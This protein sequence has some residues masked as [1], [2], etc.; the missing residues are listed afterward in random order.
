MNAC[1]NT[2][3]LIA[4]SVFFLAGANEAFGLVLD[5][6]EANSG[7]YFWLQTFIAGL[8][9]IADSVLQSGIDLNRT[10]VPLI[11][12]I[13]LL[14]SGWGFLGWFRRDTRSL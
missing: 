2:A 3:F 4:L 8:A 1:K 5:A 13:W 9:G 12:A 14:M 11:G 6:P 7:L 10:A